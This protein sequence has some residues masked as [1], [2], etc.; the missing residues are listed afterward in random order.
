MTAI[1]TG[2]RIPWHF[3]LV[4]AI[5]VLWNGYGGYDYVMSQTVGDPYFR[6][7][8]MSE[9]VIAY[10]HAYPAWMVGVWATGVWTSVLGSVLLLMRRAWAVQAFAV[11]FVAVV[12]MI[13]YTHLLT[14][15]A[16]VMGPQ[17]GVMNLV[18]TAACAFFVWYSWLMAKRG[19]LR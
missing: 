10:M 11:S 16:K 12:V 1:D 19:V 18:I 5:A 3:W 9:G 8:G 2:A 13:I 17:A 6:K 15:G 4:L 7:M 14:D